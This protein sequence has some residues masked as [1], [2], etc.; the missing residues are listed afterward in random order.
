M[1]RLT[2]SF[3]SSSHRSRWTLFTSFTSEYGMQLWLSNLKSYG[4][5]LLVF[6]AFS[7]SRFAL[8]L[9]A[10]F[11]TALPVAQNQGLIRC[12]KTSLLSAGTPT[13]WRK[14]DTTCFGRD[15]PERYPWMMTR[16]KQ[17]YTN[18]SRLPNSLTNDFI[19]CPPSIMQRQHDHRSDQPVKSH[20][21]ICFAF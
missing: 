13:I 17:W 7:A 2:W 14:K 19:G 6:F 15:N 9:P 11:V 4:R 1:V 12:D 5:F 10:T 8:A 16:S 3:L 20:F 21:Q 18:N